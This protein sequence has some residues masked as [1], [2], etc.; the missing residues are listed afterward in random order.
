M[1]E[2]N[3]W[4]K[5]NKDTPMEYAAT[6]I[7]NPLTALRMLEDFTTLNSGISMCMILLILRSFRVFPDQ[8][9]NEQE[10][11]LSKMV[12]QALWGNA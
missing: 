11:L 1:K 4:H 5:I 6:I 3:V 8:A 10:T 12:L 9:G 7:V 2:Q